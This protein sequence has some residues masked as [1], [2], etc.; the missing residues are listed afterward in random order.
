MGQHQGI[1]LVD[2]REMKMSSYHSWGKGIM[3]EGMN[4]STLSPTT[5]PAGPL[6]ISGSEFSETLIHFF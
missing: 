6:R 4:R 3:S 5:G 1:L 2:R